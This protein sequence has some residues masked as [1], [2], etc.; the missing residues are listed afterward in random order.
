[1][2]LRPASSLL[3]VAL[4]ACA[5][6]AA[7]QD[8][9]EDRL[10][11]RLG[12]MSASAETTLSASTTYM[13]EPYSFSQGFDFGSDE[14]VPRIDGMFRLSERQRLVFDYFNYDKSRRETLGQ[15]LSYDDITIP[16]GSYAEAELDFQLASLLYDYSVVQTDNFSLG[17][18]IGAEWAKAKATLVAEAGENRWTEQ[19]SEDGYAPVVGVRLTARPGERWLLNLQAQYLDADWGDF[20]DY[21]GSISRA[22]AIAEYRFTEN[23][24]LFAGYEWYRLDVKRTVTGDDMRDGIVGWDQRFK[25]PVV[26]VTM[27]F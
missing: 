4:L 7:A 12:A 16:E 10:A 27:A 3:A 8:A 25:G 1:M 14:I 9:R 5:G 23:F 17:L 24:G 2:Q 19:T 6:H 11:L 20:E 18:Q 15:D 21:D 13:D 26:G 22:N